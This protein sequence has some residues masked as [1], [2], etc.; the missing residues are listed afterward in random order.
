[1][2]YYTIKTGFQYMPVQPKA[3]RNLKNIFS[4]ISIVLVQQILSH[5]NIS[6]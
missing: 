2:F 4:F 6:L 1:M 3:C 5:K